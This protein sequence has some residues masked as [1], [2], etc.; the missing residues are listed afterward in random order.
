MNVFVKVRSYGPRPKYSF[1]SPRTQADMD[2]FNQVQRHGLPQS[3]FFTGAAS[4][5]EAIAAVELVSGTIAGEVYTS[6]ICEDQQGRLPELNEDI[7]FDLETGAIVDSRRNRR[8]R[9]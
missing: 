8:T 6:V 3:I 4:I 9:K 5:R 1:T 7:K 2:G